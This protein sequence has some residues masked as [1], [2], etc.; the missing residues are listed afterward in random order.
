VIYK[1][2]KNW[3]VIVYVGRDP[4][5][6]KQLRKSGSAPTRAEAKLLEARLVTEAAAGQQIVNDRGGGNRLHADDVVF[7]ALAVR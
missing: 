1:R 4:M 2:G 6:G 3:R 5:T 7:E